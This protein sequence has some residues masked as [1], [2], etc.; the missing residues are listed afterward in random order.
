[1]QSCKK[2]D[3]P[4]YIDRT[5]G[6]LNSKLHAV[7]NE[8]GKPVVMALTAGQ[9]SDHVGAKIVYPAL[10]GSRRLIG[11]K[12]YDSDEWRAALKAKGIEPCIPPKSNRKTAIPFDKALYKQRHR[13]ENTFAKIKDWRRIAT[14]YDRCADIFMAAITLA[15]TCI[16]WLN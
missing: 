1:M 4:R 10:P 11:D 15:V 3:V 8:A 6:G 12:G 9:V 14:R 13:I 2:E 7:I 5:K 16:F